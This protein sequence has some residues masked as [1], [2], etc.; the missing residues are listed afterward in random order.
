MPEKIF[1]AVAWPYTNGYLHLGHLAGCYV[2][3]DIFARYHRLKG[4]RVLMVSGSDQHGTPVT[5]RAEE[6]GTT[7]QEVVDKYH[8]SQQESWDRL[9]I[10]FDLFTTTGTA[11][12]REV[13]HDIFLTLL[14]KDLIY[15]STTPLPYCQTDV[16]FLPDRY[17]EGKCPFCGNPAARGD[18]CDNCGKPMDPLD[19]QDL[20]CRICGNAPEIR[21][22]E[23]FFLRLSAFQEKLLDWVRQQKHWRPNV[24]N[25]T[26]RY[27]EEGLHDRAITRDLD[28]GVPVPVP[29]YEDK[30]IYVWFEAVIGYLSAAKEWAQ[31]QDQPDAWREF[32]QGPDVRGYYF[33]GNDN[34][35]FHTIIWPGMLMGF[36][37]DLVLPYDVP[38]NEFMNLGGDKFSK[39]EHRAVWVPDYLE[40]YDP[41]PLR[42]FIASN[43]PET[44]D[45]EFT[46]QEFVRRNNDELV[47]TYGNLVHRVL[48]FLQRN[49]E[50]KVP[51]PG[52]LDD[53]AQALL[54]QVDT[55]LETV[56]REINLCR[57]REA[58]RSA[59]ALAQAANRY[60]DAQAPWRTRREYPV[61]AATSLWVT[62]CA[63][64]GLKTI[65]FPFLPFS[66]QQLHGMLGFPGEARETGWTVQRPTPGQALPEPSPLFT[67]LDDAVVEYETER[68]AQQAT[69]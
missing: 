19:L 27:L 31:L 45:T 6:E 62:L 12:H 66:A 22:S 64:A 11:N 26:T 25:F 5:L 15:T 42:Y 46:W 48:T 68:M 17:V 20:R 47:A 40:R 63:I 28:W 52:D 35:A 8:Q 43:M 65:T 39:S 34:I 53:A 21:D 57:F 50:G 1:V 67:K 30:R 29:G 14:Q 58:L 56:G 55:T 13:V 61:A 41:D 16:R 37:G 10:Q 4:N 24:L 59:M 36:E 49:F 69:G 38:A 18:Q 7:P 32:W 54:Q 9:G 60:L 33:L 44:G 23:H 3:A 51:Q 2:A